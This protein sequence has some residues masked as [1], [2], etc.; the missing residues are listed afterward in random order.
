VTLRGQGAPG[1]APRHVKRTAP[2]ASC[3]GDLRAPTLPG[4]QTL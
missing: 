4:T 2:A 3:R 1:R